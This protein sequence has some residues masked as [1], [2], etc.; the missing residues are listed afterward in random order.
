MLTF[1]EAN[2]ISPNL[3]RNAEQEC[4]LWQCLY[5]DNIP[6]TVTTRCLSWDEHKSAS[7]STLPTSFDQRLFSFLSLPSCLFIQLGVVAPSRQQMSPTL[8][9]VLSTQAKGIN[10]K[11][12]CLLPPTCRLSCHSRYLAIFLT[13]FLL[14][15]LFFKTSE[16]LT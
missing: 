15:L 2:P 10:L 16:L 4:W 11:G 5:S 7:P 1:F 13:C 9:V 12:R 3:A 14:Q 8:E 6:P